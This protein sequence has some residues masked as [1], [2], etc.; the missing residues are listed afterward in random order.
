MENSPKIPYKTTEAAYENHQNG[1]KLPSNCLGPTVP[2]LPPP[3]K[4]SRPRNSPKPPP[5]FFS[6]SLPQIDFFPPPSP[7]FPPPGY[8]PP[9]YRP[10]ISTG[11]KNFPLEIHPRKNNFP[12]PISKSLIT[13]PYYLS[14]GGKFLLPRGYPRG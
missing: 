1:L 13:I 4:V 7:V 14:A 8:P 3:K 9:S 11:K 2:S 5:P 12:P 10:P 6:S